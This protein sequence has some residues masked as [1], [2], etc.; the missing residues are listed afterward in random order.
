V[1]RGVCRSSTTHRSISIR[2]QRAALL[3]TSCNISRP[4]VA[5][6]SGAPA[7]GAD[8]TPTFVS[9]ATLLTLLVGDGLAGDVSTASAAPPGIGVVPTIDVPAPQF[10]DTPQGGVRTGGQA[11]RIEF[12]DADLND[13]MSAWYRLAYVNGG[14]R[15]RVFEHYAASS[16]GPESEIVRSEYAAWRFANR[17]LGPAGDSAASDEFP[18]GAWVRTGADTGPSAGLMFTLAD[19]DLLTPGALV[20][21]LRV[22]GTGSIG[23]DGVVSPVAGIEVK[24]AAAL[25]TRPD[26]IFAP[27]PSWFV[28]DVTIVESQLTR[29]PT[30]GHTVGEWLN[31]AGYEQAG[32]VAASHPGAV[33]VVVVHD[34]RQVLAWLCGRT[35]NVTVCQVARR[36]ANIPIGTP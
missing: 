18:R 26:V 15:L 23:S 8:M 32:R 19:I 31:V 34:V 14:T 1:T 33:E 16:R 20:G 17:V 7:H 10:W 35:D 11:A 12:D 21:D 5:V 6:L 25:L 3:S 13:G 28:D 4:V 30:A 24:V 9:F 29:H 36:S 2:P 27:R 22:A